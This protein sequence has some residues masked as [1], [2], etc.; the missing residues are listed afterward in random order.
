M[1]V[2]GRQFHWVMSCDQ[3]GIEF[4]GGLLGLPD[5]NEDLVLQVDPVKQ[6]RGIKFVKNILCG[7]RLEKPG[8][9]SDLVV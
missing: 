5:V 6:M 2:Y 1:N 3:V 4:G 8:S 7:I 9:V